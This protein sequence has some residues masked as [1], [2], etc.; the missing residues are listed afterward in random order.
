MSEASAAAAVPPANGPVLA[1]VLTQQLNGLLEA[2]NYDG[3]K[4]LLQPVQEVDIAEAIG[5]LP[6]TLQALAFRLLP[7]NE[8]IAVYEYLE[9]SVQQTLLERL[10]SSE[11]LELVEE[12]SPDDRVDLFD[13]LPAK[14]VRRL[15]A[16]LSPAERRVTAQLLGYEPETAG[17]LMTT[18]FIDLKE[19]HSVAQALTIVR[20][21]ARDTETIYA[22]YVTDASRHLTGILSLRDLVVADP[23]ERVGD[24]MT[25]EVVS[26]GTDTDQEEVARV[27]QRYD[28]LAV[29]VVDREQRLVGIVTVDDVIDVIQQE[30]TRDLY[31]AGAVQAGDEDDYFQ[32]NLVTVARRRVV[33]LLVLLLANSGTAAVIASMDDVL[34]KVVVLAAF[35][36]LLIGTGGNVGAQ[37][38]TVV[39][40]GLSTQRIQA[41]GPA[42]AIGREALA[43][44][45]LGL[46]MVLVVVPW[47]MYVSGGN[48]VVAGAAGISL[49][50]I[51]TLAATAGAALPLLFDRIGLDPAL[52]SAPFIATATDVA[53]VFI[54][55]RTASWLLR[56][57]G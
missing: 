25:R 9:P 24:V 21:R 15:L 18:E 1:E 36:P 12:M 19:F 54:Y 22:L 17:R 42:Q 44:A 28:F 23:E 40:R 57:W 41:L 10:R 55:L 26:V 11:V 34:H 33:W 38:S 30:A 37:S 52:M 49:V 43:G 50:A 5:G 14:V 13:E 2:G 8:A 51:T 56:S 32:S 4:L 29:P 27:I 53:G 45:L 35:I 39:I 16:E 47:S 20:R 46:L 31:A 48:L 3:V 7:K 6:R